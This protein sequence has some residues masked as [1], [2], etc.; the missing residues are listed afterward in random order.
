MAVVL[1]FSLGAV[2]SPAPTAAVMDGITVTIIECP[3]GQIVTPCTNFGIKAEITNNTGGIAQGVVASIAIDGPASVIDDMPESWALPNMD[4][5]ATHIVGW[6]VHCDEPGDV[7]VTVTANGGSDTCSFQQEEPAD[8]EVTVDAPCEVGIGCGENIFDVDVTVENTGDVGAHD[9]VVSIA[10]SGP[11]SATITPPMQ[12]TVGNLAAGALATKTWSVTCTG[13]GE[14]TFTGT[15][16]GFED[17]T[18]TALG[19][20]TGSDATLQKEVIV[21]VTRVWDGT[22]TPTPPDYPTPPVLGEHFTWDIISTLDTFEVTARAFN[23]TNV[24]QSMKIELALPAGTQLSGALVKVKPGWATQ[25]TVPAATTVSVNNICACCCVDITWELECTESTG[26][27]AAEIVVTARTLTDEELDVNN[28]CQFAYVIQENKVHLVTELTTWVSDCDSAEQVNAVALGQEF[29][30]QV[31]MTNSGEAA[32]I[33]VLIDV[34]ISGDVSCEGTYPGLTFGNIAGETTVEKWLHADLGVPLCCC[35]DEGTVTI[36]ITGIS[37]DDLN[38]CADIPEENIEPP[39]PLLVEQKPFKVIIIQPEFCDDIDMCTTFTVKAQ[40]INESLTNDLRDVVVTL[41]WDPEGDVELETGQQNPITIPLIAHS[42]P[43]KTTVHEVTWQ[44]RCVSEGDVTFH[45]CAESEPLPGEHLQVQDSNVP[46]TLYSGSLGS[47]TWDDTTSYTGNKSVKLLHNASGAGSVYVQFVPE[48]G[49]LLGQ[50]D[51]ITADPEWSFWYWLED[52]AEDWGPQL[53]LKFEDP[54]SAGYAEVTIMALQPAAPPVLETWTKLTV[55]PTTSRVA[56]YGLADDESTGLMVGDPTP[57]L[58][59]GEIEAA[60]DAATGMSGT[61]ANWEFTRVRVELWEALARYCYID[62]ITVDGMT[63]LPEVTIHQIAPEPADV[64]MEIVSPD[65]LDTL[66][67]TSQDFA[68]TAIIA[69]NEPYAT[70]TINEVDLDWH[71]ENGVSLVEGDVQPVVPFYIPAGESRTITWTLHCE[72]TGMV[73]ITADAHGTSEICQPVHAMGVPL[74]LWQYPAAH[75]EVQ[76]LSLSEPTV[77]VSEPFTVTADI[78]NTGKADATEVSATLSVFPEGSAQITEGGYTQLVGTIPREGSQTNSKPVSWTL[79]CKE[80]CDTTITINVTGFDEYGWHKKQECQSTGNF[81]VEAG[82][83]GIAPMG[84]VV[85]NIN[86]MPTITG[87]KFGIL[88]GES[89]GLIG[90]FI[91]QAAV[92]VHPEDTSV[93]LEGTLSLMGAVIPDLPPSHY[94]ALLQCLCGRDPESCNFDLLALLEWLNMQGVNKDAM[95]YIGVLQLPGMETEC[96]SVAGGLFTIINGRIIGGELVFEQDGS[97]PL[98]VIITDGEYCSTMAKEA[99]REIDAKFIEPDSVTVKQLEPPAEADLAVTKVVDATEPVVV[100][101]EVTFTVTLENLGEADATSIWVWDLLPAGVNFKHWNA[102][103]GFYYVGS[104]YWSV[105]DLDA[106]ASA[107][108]TIVATVTTVGEIHNLA[109]VDY[110]DQHDPITG[111]NADVVTITGLEAAVPASWP[112]SL[113][114]GYNLISLPFYIDPEDRDIDDDVLAGILGNVDVVWAYDACEPDPELRWDNFATTGPMGYLTEMRDGP[115]YWLVMTGS[116]VLTVTGEVLPLAPETPPTYEV[117]EGW[118]LIGFKSTAPRL[119][120]DYLA[121]IA[122]NYTIIYGYDNGSYF[123]AG[124][125]GHESLLPGQGF[126]IAVIEPGTIY[127]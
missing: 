58:S 5:G 127:P 2:F 106:F 48:A 69:N 22:C 97:P 95:V 9:V 116:D 91:I 43:E 126:W 64:T 53:E 6:T 21:S 118:N 34:N 38:T 71:P 61:C 28:D 49:L 7:T 109:T 105:G 96:Y 85:A 112:I 56:A 70:V 65:N 90:P 26:G 46:F 84:P 72:D 114:V 66:I 59:L 92:K 17:N 104:G 50:L 42:V 32:A 47:G 12:Q 3:G 55:L 103:Q 120:E 110:C 122:G 23:Y 76:N 39:C 8:L 37:G 1:I 93:V 16:S 57:I 86:G 30:V 54:D 36:Q 111:N 88:F 14:V 108:L 94:E 51:A 77:N 25:Y 80:A 35:E 89:S 68:V 125:P 79:H 19:P 75:L 45:V 63:Y 124:S 121:G 73:V 24:P 52:T 100:G 10:K 15:A 87:G 40:L 29:D 13:A 113:D 78:V 83:Y 41:N 81:I 99:L 74:V 11:G 31:A 62:D 4:A 107:T 115:G 44:V 102:D 27:Q 20:A 60:I 33:G 119:P 67:A 117:C 82:C 98:V 18:G 101:T 123:I